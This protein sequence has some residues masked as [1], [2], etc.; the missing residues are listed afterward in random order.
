[1]ASFL[2]FVK[3]GARGEEQ[4]RGFR[5]LGRDVPV[6]RVSYSISYT[7]FARAGHGGGYTEVDC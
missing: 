4:G 1:M 5:R 2:V 7:S 3:R 6:V